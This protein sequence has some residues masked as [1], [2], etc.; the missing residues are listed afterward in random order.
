[1]AV[2]N[3]FDDA[4]PAPPAEHNGGSNGAA[5]AAVPPPPPPPAKFGAPAKKTAQ[6]TPLSLEE[7][8]KKKQQDD[9]AAAKPVFMSKKQRDALAQQKK[10]REESEQQQQLQQREK[11]RLKFANGNPSSKQSSMN[12]HRK[13]VG[14]GGIPTGPAAMRQAEPMPPPPL[15]G[16]RNARKQVP[17]QTEEEAV[18]DYVKQRYLGNQPT[19]TFSASKKRKRTTDKKFNFD[20]SAEE[21]TSQ[22]YNPIYQNRLDT[23]TF[24]RGHGGGLD[25]DD[26]K[27]RE[28]ARA[29]AE[30]DT[31]NGSVRAQ[32]LKIGRA[33]V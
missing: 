4:P 11:D 26:K 10:L 8:L 27:V 28:Y 15:S 14:P 18:A 5:D 33:H 7:I 31:E 12:G 2:S 3:H 23:T 16:S 13:P 20:W 6:K 17:R 30:R 24:G 32:Q 29:I 21:D 1:M 9:E 19:S 22:D 25:T